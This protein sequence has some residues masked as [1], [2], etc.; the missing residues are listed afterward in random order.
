MSILI[1]RFMPYFNFW[2]HG[3][4]IHNIFYISVRFLFQQF[5]IFNLFEDA[6][7]ADGY[8]VQTFQTFALWDTV[9]DEDCIEIFKVGEAD[10]L[11]DGGIVAYIFKRLRPA[12]FLIVAN[13]P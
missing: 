11:V 12:W 6:H 7:L 13:S 2:F 8:L 5:S 10:K 4:K 1:L 9:A 3:A